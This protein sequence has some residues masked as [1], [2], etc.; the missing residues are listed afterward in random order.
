VS[1]R[2]YPSTEKTLADNPSHDWICR[3]EEASEAR[4]VA[5]ELGKTPAKL[6]R[7]G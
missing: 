4:T 3:S 7:A 1:K 5:R 6:G 2:S